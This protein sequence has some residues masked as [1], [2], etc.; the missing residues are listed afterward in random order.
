LGCATEARS[1][2]ASSD[3]AT[4]STTAGSGRGRPAGGIAPVRSLRTIFSK[5]SVW[6]LTAATSN[7]SSASPPAFMRWLWHVVQYVSNTAR[8]AGF[9]GCG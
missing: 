7:V 4:L 1:R 3:D 5:T 9:A 2:L 6:S 8:G